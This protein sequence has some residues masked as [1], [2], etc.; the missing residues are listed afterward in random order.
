MRKL[1]RQNRPLS[2]L[3]SHFNIITR[4]PSWKSLRPVLG[5]NPRL[6]TADNRWLTIIIIYPDFDKED[7]YLI[8]TKGNR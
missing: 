1:S 8:L 2:G 5:S 6:E 3:P 4:D 7:T